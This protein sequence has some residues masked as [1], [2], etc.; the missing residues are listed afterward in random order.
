MTMTV[1][2][3]RDVLEELPDD[4]EVRLMTQSNYPLEFSIIGTWTVAP[5]PDACGNCGR[6]E[7]VH[8]VGDQD[9]PLHS[10][11]PYIDFEPT[12]PHTD[13]VL[14]LL[15]GTQLGYGTKSA[16]EEMDFPITDEFIELHR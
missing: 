5:N 2:Q 14:Y 11:V 1:A 3:L 9:G 15:E 8:D 13:E 4:A 6:I 12:K 7:A 16:W 10:F